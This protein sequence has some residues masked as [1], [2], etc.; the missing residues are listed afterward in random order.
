MHNN[1]KVI[2]SGSL[3]AGVDVEHFVHDFMQQFKVP[4]AQARKLATVGKTL[5]LKENLAHDTA[6]KYRQVMDNL[7]MQ[8]HVEAPSSDLPALKMEAPPAPQP[9][10]QPVEAGDHTTRCPKCGSTRVKDDDCLACGIIISRYNERQ[11]RSAA[12]VAP[13]QDNP[14]A[15]P[16]AD[17]TLVSISES[18][19]MNGPHSVPAGNGWSW[20]AGGWSHF[21]R[22]PLAWIGAFVVWLL[23]MMFVSLIPFLGSVAINLLAPVL[24]AGLLLGADE[25]RKGGNF[26][27]RHLFAAFSGNAGGLVLVG[28]FYM[29]GTI[30][31]FVI[32]AAVAGGAL[33]TMS[34]TLESGSVDP[35][36]MMTFGV[37]LLLALL[38]AMALWIPLLMAYWFAP[39]LVAL[40]GIAPFA[41]M[42]LSFSACLKNILPYLVYSIIALVL[43]V[44][45]L[46][47]F[48]LGMFVLL[49]V[50]IATMYTSYRDIF[51]ATE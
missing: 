10:I 41:A 38:L 29:I 31:I 15:P 18:G 46:I 32:A 27:V 1:Y 47:P 22:N 43:M 28:L 44:V 40:E 26:E 6:E 13:H 36:A 51:Y 24:T 42:K 16:Q 45:A 20:I 12:E 17:L 49:P 7:G 8:V 30:I 5:T 2:Y 37:P 48:G 3:K 19:E 9:A 21:R 33:L 11:A 35:Q 50:L 14:Y 25:Q 34:S 4:E 23:V 39:A